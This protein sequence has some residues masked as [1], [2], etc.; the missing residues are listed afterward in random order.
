M[1]LAAY[2]DRSDGTTKGITASRSETA[3]DTRA[4][5]AARAVRTRRSRHPSF[6]PSFCSAQTTPLDLRS[7]SLCKRKPGFALLLLA[8]WMASAAARMPAPATSRQVDIK[9]PRLLCPSFLRS[10]F[11]LPSPAQFL[12]FL[13]SPN[14]LALS[15]GCFQ[16][17]SLTA[18]T[19]LS[20]PH[21]R[22]RSQGR[23]APTILI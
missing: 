3:S 21:T 17:S 22:N 4:R 6:S 23:A 7:R 20:S 8:E 1:M 2:H 18:A 14:A 13:L 15:F 11:L 12:P 10:S 19:V 5:T 9:V 16:F